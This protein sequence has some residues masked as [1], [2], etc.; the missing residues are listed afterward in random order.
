MQASEI[1]E[2]LKVAERPDVISFA[3]GIPDPALFPQ[4]HIR[5]AYDEILSDPIL[6]GKA[7][8]YSLSEGDADLRA[9][10]ATHMG[11]KGIACSP[12]NILITNGAQQALE[13]LGKLF[14]SPGD[15]ALVQA[16]TYLGA[17]QAFAPNQPIY[18]DLQLE[19]TNRTSSSYRSTAKAN[20][21]H[22]RFSYVVPDFANPTGE[23]MSEGARGKLL[24][25][26]HRLNIPI[27]ED[28]PYAPLRFEGQPVRSIMA[29]DIDQC[30]GIE[31]SKVIHCGT[32]SKIFTPGLRVGWVCARKDII[33]RL[34]LIKQA[35][36]LNSPAI[37]QLVM[38][39]LARGMYDTQVSKT[40]AHYRQKRD[41][42]LEALEKYMPNGTIW[43]RP[44]G[45]MFIW[46]TLAKDIDTAALLPKAVA[47]CGVAY[48]PG[49][50]FF[51][52]KS[53]NNMLRLSYSLP[54]ISKITPGIAK[55]AEHFCVD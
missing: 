26:A 36:D 30:G 2:L 53:A 35:S 13:F 49:H 4:N 15:T 46:L 39:H 12:D 48:V 38:L 27:V 34:C 3:G 22:V 29:L 28:S 41:V 11:S 50:A 19:N 23:T 51:A 20:D 8:Q 17:L 9:W 45:G 24:D 44:K 14:I 6:A 16:Q 18:D 32:F 33:A 5:K 40:I 42:M 54:S 10:I 25:L 31:R 43:S 37:N 47:Q 1:R 52:D 55:L 21:S 7:L